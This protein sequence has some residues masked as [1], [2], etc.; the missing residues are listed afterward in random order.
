MARLAVWLMALTVAGILAYVRVA[1]EAEF[2]FASVVILPVFAVSW[3]VR[4]KEGVIYS[5]LA[6][7]VWVSADIEA[8]RQFSA[9]WI[10]WANGLTHFV[11]YALVAY[12]TATLREVLVREY[13]LAR[14][15]A[16][17]GLLNRR[18]FFESGVAE[19]A[20]AKRYGHSLGIVFLDLDD[21]KQLND[22]RRHEV[23]DMA[24]KVVGDALKRSLRNTDVVARLG[25]DEF[26]AILPETTF[27][28]ATEAGNKIANAIN[29]VL[30][31]F[32]PVSVSLGVAWF[33]NVT[34]CFVE[35]VNAADGLMYE[36]KE[37]GKHGVRSKKFTAGMA[38]VSSDE[39]A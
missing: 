21:F 5:A 18:A 39:A 34:D 12:L 3:F 4:K 15:D 23:G 26:A 30:R 9:A 1:T 31:D 37:A 27:E 17:S 35:M 25:G 6:A 20:R 24:L 7:G 29:A 22:A 11:V 2:A 14:H 19:T 13:D 16:L 32:S 10:P 36:I 33:E 8:G 28:S 38:G